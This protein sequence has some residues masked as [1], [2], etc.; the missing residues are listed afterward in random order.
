MTDHL[1]TVLDTAVTVQRQEL[2]RLWGRVKNI[3][4]NPLHIIRRGSILR[5]NKRS[6]LR[7]DTRECK[8]ERK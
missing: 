8:T 3:F 4:S 5:T 1:I 2:H 7:K 6:D